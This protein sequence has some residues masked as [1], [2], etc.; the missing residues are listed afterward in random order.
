MRILTALAGL[1]LVVLGFVLFLGTHREHGGYREAPACTTPTPGPDADCLLPEN[2]RVTEKRRTGDFENG[3]SY[4]L[5]VARA[6]GPAEEYEVDQSLYLDVTAGADVDL[7]V[8]K[9]RVVRIA[10]GGHATTPLSLPWS[11]FP[12]L[13]GEALLI[14]AGTALTAHAL[15]GR[16]PARWGVTPLL[17]P[18]T[19]L[20][21]FLGVAL[22][23]L[24]QLPFPVTLGLAV[25]AWL[26][27]APVLRRLHPAASP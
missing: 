10:H 7:E 12:T 17:F 2:G 5:S 19:A 24:L 22:L 8:W 20:P 4:Y 25:T 9:D 27:T 23:T 13:A 26:I 11:L 15:P 18:V 1:P 21:T 6:T 14:A 16:N 3:Y